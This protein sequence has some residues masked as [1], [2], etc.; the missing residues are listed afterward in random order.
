MWHAVFSNDAV[1]DMT[2]DILFLD[3][4]V[5]WKRGTPQSSVLD[6]DFPV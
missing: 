2:I 1:R 6:W 3:M 4:E 5:S